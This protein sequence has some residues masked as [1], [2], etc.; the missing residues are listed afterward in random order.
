MTLQKGKSGYNSEFVRSKLELDYNP[1]VLL[2]KDYYIV[3]DKPA[4]NRHWSMS[5]EE[6]EICDRAVKSIRQGS[7]I[8]IDWNTKSNFRTTKSIS[9]PKVHIEP[10]RDQNGLI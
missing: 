1:I 5:K 10:E 7:E 8:R 9:L 4:R 3:S 6:S 2:K